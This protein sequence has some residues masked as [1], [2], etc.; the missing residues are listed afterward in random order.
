MPIAQPKSTAVFRAVADSTR[1]SLLDLLLE[2]EHSVNELRVRFRISQPAISQHLSVLRRAGL[3]RVRREGRRR[4]YQLNARPI[5]RVYSWAANYKAF[6]DPEG[7]AW[8]IRSQ[9][10]SRQNAESRKEE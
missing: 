5:A 6:F 4:L 10:D 3:V 7:H 8:L 2:H 9:E 1:R